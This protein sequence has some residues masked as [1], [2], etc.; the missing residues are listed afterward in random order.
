MGPLPRGFLDQ[1]TQTK[2]GQATQTKRL[3]QLLASNCVQLRI[4]SVGDDRRF[5]RGQRCAP[6]AGLPCDR[7]LQRPPLFG[8]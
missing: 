6:R 4:V 1:A 2:R 3:T 5:A 8:L 7:A